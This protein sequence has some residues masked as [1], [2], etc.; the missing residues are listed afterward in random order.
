[1]EHKTIVIKKLV[2]DV[3]KP[4]DPSIIDMATEIASLSGVDS[5]SITSI[6]IDR[7][8]E[9]VKVLV[10]GNDIRLEKVKTAIERLGGVI[11]SIDEVVAGRMEVREEETLHERM[12]E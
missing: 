10:E 9:S 1:M 8:T 11:H 6:E 12:H 7:N 4:L 3:L 5:V 2:L